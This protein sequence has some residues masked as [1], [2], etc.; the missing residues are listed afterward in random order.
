MGANILAEFETRVEKNLKPMYEQEFSLNES[1]A[2]FSLISNDLSA[3][4]AVFIQKL[5]E[6]DVDGKEFLENTRRLKK[7]S[8]LNTESYNNLIIEEIINN[9]N[10]FSQ[11]VQNKISKIYNNVNSRI[12]EVLE[13][14]F[15]PLEQFRAANLNHEPISNFPISD[16]AIDTLLPA[17]ETVEKNEEIEFASV[18]TYKV[19]DDKVVSEAPISHSS[20]ESKKLEPHPINVTA[21][22]EVMRLSK[23]IKEKKES[24]KLREGVKRTMTLRAT[25]Y[26]LSPESCGKPRNHPLYGI[27]YT[28]TKAKANRTV[29]V[30]PGIIPLGSRLNITFPDKY[31]HMNGIYFAEDTSKEA[32]GNFIEVFLGE[33]K[34]GSREIY[35]RAMMFGVQRI[36]VEILEK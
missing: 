25:A 6:G 5:L 13:S 27:T 8:K 24:I 3:V 23:E 15:A 22:T 16:E 11:C 17:G 18:V 7:I 12:G 33:D 30:D 32:K 4:E 10:G 34:D 29:A 14:F 35:D 9:K 19:A 2:D 1:M 21:F 36:E 28:G 20:N 26:D 31:K